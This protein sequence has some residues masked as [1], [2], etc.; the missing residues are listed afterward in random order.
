MIDDDDARRFRVVVN[1]VDLGRCP[2]AL[3]DDADTVVRVAAS[4]NTL[5]DL[6]WGLGADEVELT[7]GSRVRLEA[8]EDAT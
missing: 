5:C 8:N 4:E 7:N 6:A 2:F 3:L 1:E